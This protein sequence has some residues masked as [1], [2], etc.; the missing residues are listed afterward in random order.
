[1]RCK[2]LK[3]ACAALLAALLC[4]APR[5]GAA[6]EG[7]YPGGLHD[8][9]AVTVVA[10]SGSV[11]VQSGASAFPA[12]AGLILAPGDIVRTGTDG[13]AVIGYLTD[14]RILIWSNSEFRIEYTGRTGVKEKGFDYTHASGRVFNR[15]GGSY[16]GA[17]KGYAMVP[18]A[19]IVFTDAEFVTVADGSGTQVAV[20]RGSVEVKAQ[21]WTKTLNARQQITITASGAPAAAGPVSDILDEQMSLAAQEM[22]TAKP[23]QALAQSNSYLPRTIPQYDTRSKLGNTA[24]E[25]TPYYRPERWGTARDEYRD[26]R[27]PLYNKPRTNAALPPGETLDAEIWSELY[28][29]ADDYFQRADQ[30]YPYPS[31]PDPLTRG[32]GK[33]LKT[34]APPPVNVMTPRPR[35][36]DLLVGDYSTAYRLCQDYSSTQTEIDDCIVRRLKPEARPGAVK[37][38]ELPPELNL[39]M[40]HEPQTPAY[41]TLPPVSELPPPTLTGGSMAAP[42]NCSFALFRNPML[43]H[44]DTGVDL[45]NQGRHAAALETFEDALRVNPNHPEILNNIAAAYYRMGDAKSAER[46]LILALTRD[47]ENPTVH[48]TLGCALMDQGRT[49]Q[50]CGEWEQVLK[51]QPQQAQASRNRYAFCNVGLD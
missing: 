37:Y 25:D 30:G 12:R 8:L 32:D 34:V 22:A 4:V 11:T 21:G 46:F 7:Q 47:Q 39:P 33:T 40:S 9:D 15:V 23:G 2:A 36:S 41:V 38:P 13:K 14:S 44:N 45:L 10:V 49:E 29:G 35:V 17:T 16:F 48:N 26:F 42:L 19:S 1:M 43:K 6:Q 27:S 5:M 20:R 24:P 3:L 50:A 51:M 18:G 31:A 28:K